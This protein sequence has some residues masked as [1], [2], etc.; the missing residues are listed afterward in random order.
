MAGQKI[1]RF[2]PLAR[3]RTRP[4]NQAES[5]QPTPVLPRHKNWLARMLDKTAA[6]FLF[7]FVRREIIEAYRFSVPW[8]MYGVMKIFYRVERRGTRHYKYQP[9]TI[10]ACGHKRDTDIPV[11]LPGLYQFNPRPLRSLHI[12]TRDDVIEKGFFILYFPMLDFMRKWVDRI[13]PE[14]WF[15]MVKCCPVKLPDEQTVNQLLHETIRLEGNLSANDALTPEWQAKL[16]ITQPNLTLQ[17]AILRAPLKTL[18]QYAT[19]RM[20]ESGLANR[21]RQRHHATCIQQLNDIVRVLEKGGTLLVHP[22]GQVTPDGRF[23]KMRA[24]ITRIIVQSRVDTI[25]LPMN[26]TYDFMDSAFRTN[27]TVIAGEQI[28][29]LKQYAKNELAEIIRTSVSRLGCVTLSGVAARWLVEAANRNIDSITLG[30]FREELWQEVERLRKA[31]L[32]LDRQLQN[33]RQFENRFARFIKWSE[34]HAGLFVKS[35]TSTLS[36]TALLHLDLMA[37]RREE[38]YKFTDN[39]ARYCYNELTELLETWNALP[40]KKAQPEPEE[41]EITE[42]AVQS[43]G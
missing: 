34:K 13:S 12:A 32:H 22:Q 39:P 35:V 9:S 43:A 1:I 20:F 26:V 19:P 8:Q 4:E 16:Q 37:L 30:K 42:Q 2:R 40:G 25:L 18:G 41:E 23:S 17:D 21:I 5:G 15:K 10:I 31:G 24:A 7:K 28:S 11:M 38:C 14:G 27:A 6:P 3:L 33:R 29:N 36:D